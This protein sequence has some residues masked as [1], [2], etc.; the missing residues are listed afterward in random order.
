VIERT[1]RYLGDNGGEPDGSALGDEYTMHS[2]CFSG[3]QHRAEIVRIFHSIEKD[4]KWRLASFLRPLENV[5]RV[6]VGFCRDERD[7]T[8][9]FSARHQ[10]VERRLG[11]DMNRNLPRSRQLNDISELPIDAKHKDTLQRASVR[12]E[13]F[14]DGVQPI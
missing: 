8:L 3:A 6:A 11:L 2:S 13:C 10:S 7:D 14:P 4:E 12:A 9:V 5:L 1:G